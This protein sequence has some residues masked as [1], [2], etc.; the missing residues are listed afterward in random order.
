ML[1]DT[2]DDEEER[3]DDIDELRLLLMLERD[4]L[5][6]LAMGGRQRGGRPMR[7]MRLARRIWT[8]VVQVLAGETEAASTVPVDDRPV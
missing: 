4:E 1:D 3:D 7:S 2:D 8:R 5:L 6:L